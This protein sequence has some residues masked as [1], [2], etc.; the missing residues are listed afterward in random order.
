MPGLARARR[1]ARP[2]AAPA[3]A[4]RRAAAGPASSRRRARARQRVA[5]LRGCAQSVLDPGINEAAIRLLN[6]QR[7]R[8]RAGRGRGLLRRARP[9]HGPRRDESH[10]AARNN[11]D[12]WTREID[13]EGLDAI[14]ITTSGCG[15][16]IKDYGFMLRNDPAYAEKAAR[17][18]ALA[19]D[20]SEYLETLDLGAPATRTGADGRLSRRLLAAAR[21]AGQ[22][23][24]EDAARARRLR[25]ARRRRGPS[26]LR[27]GRHLQH[28]PAGDLRRGCATARSPTSRRPAPTSSPPAIS[29][30]SPR[31]PAAPTL[32]VVHTVELLDWAYGGPKPEQ[33]AERLMAASG[34]PVPSSE[35]EPQPS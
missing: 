15:T 22:D 32:P 2:R 12:A 26:L 3:A 7:R 28:A 11:V 6:R 30:A 10:A 4:A 21:P 24:A 23:R 1:H 31:S 13:G 17:V 20:I 16:T 9:S 34:S 29:A 33:L 18:S 25:G 35:P 5:L 14:V 27:L 19:K 8:G